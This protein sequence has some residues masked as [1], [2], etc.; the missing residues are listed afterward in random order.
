MSRLTILILVTITT[1]T[2]YGQDKADDEQHGFR[3]DRL[4]TGGSISFGLGSNTFQVGATPV[5]G[6]S[7]AKWLDAGVVA[8]YNYVSYRDVYANND[9]LRSSTYGGGAFTKIYPLR[10]LFAQAQFE[11]NFIRQKYIPGDNGFGNETNNVEANSLLVGA[12]IA[13]DRYAG[14]SRPFFY[15][16]LLFDVLDNKYS[17]YLRTDGSKM[18]ILR[19]GIQVPLFQGRSRF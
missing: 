10:F 18:P 19:A 11:H 8:N 6:Y 16:A 7:I 4:F 13:T 5:F 14:D 2:A 15:L 9:K 12:G 17:P 3:K 1:I